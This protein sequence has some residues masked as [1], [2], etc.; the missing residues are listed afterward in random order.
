MAASVPTDGQARTE[1]RVAAYKQLAA[2]VG[3]IAIGQN[4]AATATCPW[5]AAASACYSIMRK[6]DPYDDLTVADST[7]TEYN[8]TGVHAPVTE[9]AGSGLTA[10]T[11]TPSTGQ[12]LT[13]RQE[14]AKAFNSGPTQTAAQAAAEDEV[15]IAT[16]GLTCGTAVVPGTTSTWVER[17]VL[18]PAPGETYSDYVT[19]LRELGWLGTITLHTETALESGAGPTS[20]YANAPYGAPTVVKVGVLSPLPVYSPAGVYESAPVDAPSI[21]AVDTGIEITVKPDTSTFPPNPGGGFDFTPLTALDPGCKFPYGFITCYAVGV[22]EWFD[23]SPDAPV[24]DFDVDCP[25]LA[26]CSSFH[27]GPVDLDV[28]DSYMD[29]WRTLLSVVL[30]IGAVYYVANRFLGFH[31]GGD[32]GAAMDDVM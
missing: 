8:A 30:W 32:P 3:A 19:R 24:F 9:I 17:T 4:G 31:A 5:G 11:W 18:W 10:N 20:D 2:K 16:G 6:V 7:L 27:Y 21:P 14:G 25:S 22:T 15:C 13:E 23:V 1:S 29:V 28:I 12:G 26:P